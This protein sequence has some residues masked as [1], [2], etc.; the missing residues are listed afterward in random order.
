LWPDTIVGSFFLFPSFVFKYKRETN[1]VGRPIL[2]K[3]QLSPGSWAKKKEKPGRQA[4]FAT[5]TTFACLIGCSIDWTTPSLPL[6]MFIVRVPLIP[7]LREVVS[8]CRLPYAATIH[9]VSGDGVHLFG[10]ELELPRLFGGD[11]PRRLFFWASQDAV[12]TDPFD[13]AALQALQFLQSIYHFS[14]LDYSSEELAICTRLAR[15]M[16][17]IANTGTRLARIVLAE[18][19]TA[20]PSSSSAASVADDLLHEVHSISDFL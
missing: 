20:T 13:A 9:E 5:N 6:T 8:C 18:A 3:I 11:V 4:Y 7:V 17:S 10:V 19:Q 1:Q 15:R 16:F 2:K 12:S 14:V